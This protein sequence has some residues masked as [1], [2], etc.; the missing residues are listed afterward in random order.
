[1]EPLQI[2]SDFVLKSGGRIHLPLHE[3]FLEPIAGDLA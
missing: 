2:I 1:M 3:L